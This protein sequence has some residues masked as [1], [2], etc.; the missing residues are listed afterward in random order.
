MKKLVKKLEKTGAR[1]F[2]CWLKTGATAF[3]MI[4]RWAG[5]EVS[6]KNG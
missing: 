2:L 5:I 4:A 1:H 3:F 6:G